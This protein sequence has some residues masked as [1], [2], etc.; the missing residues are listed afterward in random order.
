MSCA[1]QVSSH[2]QCLPPPRPSQ[3]QSCS[4]APLTSCASQIPRT[5]PGHLMHD[6]SGALGIWQSIAIASLPTGI[7]KQQKIL[8]RQHPVVI[9][10]GAQ[11]QGFQ[12]VRHCQ[13][14]VGRAFIDHKRPIKAIEPFALSFFSRSDSFHDLFYAVLLS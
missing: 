7:C 1:P 3:S 4:A 2:E 10:D 14:G 6:E 12:A 13:F 8:F 11:I 5:N 9:S